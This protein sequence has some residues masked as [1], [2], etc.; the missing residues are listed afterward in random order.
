M[1]IAPLGHAA[2]GI[3]CKIAEAYRAEHDMYSITG[4]LP[5]VVVGDTNAGPA[6][7]G[8]NAIGWAPQGKTRYGYSYDKILLYKGSGSANGVPAS[9]IV[10]TVAGVS[11]AT[12]IAVASGDVGGGGGN[13]SDEWTYTQDRV[14]TNTK[15]GI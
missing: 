11:P 14:L 2:G 3:G 5:A 8:S 1:H 10:A 9:C 4:V 7:V 6:V 13:D 15:I 12:F